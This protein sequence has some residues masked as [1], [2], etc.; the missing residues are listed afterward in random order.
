M[1]QV[2]SADSGEEPQVY[3]CKLLEVLLLE[4]HGKVD[5]VFFGILFVLLVFFVVYSQYT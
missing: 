3:A 2:L 4:C 5:Q 1:L